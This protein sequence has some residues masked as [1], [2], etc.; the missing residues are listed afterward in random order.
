MARARNGDQRA[1]EQLVER[2]APQVYSLGYRV[3][4]SPA[5]AEDVAQEAFL[6]AWLALPNFRGDARFGTWLYR[7]VANLCY[8]RMPSLR[9][10]MLDLD[11]EAIEEQP[12]DGKLVDA[13][14]LATDLQGA[15]DRAMD[16]LPESHRLLLT[17]RHL[18]KMSYEEIA[19]A[20]G[21]PMGTVKI[22]LHRARGRLRR[23]LMEEGYVTS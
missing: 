2:H 17:L 22:G 6:R 3:L 4:G 12:V 8:N 20:T 7:I 15:I 16:A 13:D 14:L 21:L 5:E 18:Q 11:L 23:Q 1:F 10:G 19:T 9:R